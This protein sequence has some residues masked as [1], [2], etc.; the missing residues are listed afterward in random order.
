MLQF[1]LRTTRNQIIRTLLLV[2]ELAVLSFLSG[3]LV[4]C[5]PKLRPLLDQRN[6]KITHTQFFNH[7]TIY[8]KHLA[9][10]HPKAL[11]QLGVF[12]SCHPTF[13]RS[14]HVQAAQH[15]IWHDV[16]GL[17]FAKPK[18]HKSLKRSKRRFIFWKGLKRINKNHI[19]Y[20]KQK[21]QLFH[22]TPKKASNQITK[23]SK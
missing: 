15:A 1:H 18:Q 8:S 4:T 9:N 16:P 17:G 21:K 2:E 13:K 6:S 22:S 20:I 23:Q 19:K 10:Q 5:F 7:K 12:S 11:K 14:A 3:S